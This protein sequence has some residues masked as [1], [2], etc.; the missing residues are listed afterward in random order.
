MALE[1]SESQATVEELDQIP[2]LKLLAFFRDCDFRPAQEN[3]EILGLPS[4]DTSVMIS[5]SPS[6]KGAAQ[7]DSDDGERWLS[8]W[9]GI[10][11]I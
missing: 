9:K 4:L 1:A 2:A 6:L 11:Y 10:G 7:L 3:T 8:Y 5:M